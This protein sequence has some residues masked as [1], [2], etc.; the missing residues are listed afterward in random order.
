MRDIHRVHTIIRAAN[1]AV[2]YIYTLIFQ[3]TRKNQREIY[4]ADPARENINLLYV[5][6]NDKLIVINIY[7]YIYILYNFPTSHSWMYCV[8]VTASVN[9][10]FDQTCGA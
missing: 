7:I 2:L 9:F 5:Y 3:N 10:R 8:I 6:I 4:C 1:F